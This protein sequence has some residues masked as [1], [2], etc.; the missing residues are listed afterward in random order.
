MR[1][2]LIAFALALTLFGCTSSYTTVVEPP[3]P[4]PNP[5]PNP[6]L[7]QQDIGSGDARIPV[8]HAT[9]TEFYRYQK[10][11]ATAPLA[12]QRA[13]RGIIC[14][15][16]DD[17]S[18]DRVML[19][20]IKELFGE[21]M[22]TECGGPAT[23]H[24]GNTTVTHCFLASNVVAHCHGNRVVCIIANQYYSGVM[25]HEA[26]HALS[27]AQKSDKYKDWRLAWLETLYVGK[28]WSTLSG[29]MS[30]PRDGFV[31]AYATKNHDEDMADVVAA[32]YLFAHRETLHV[33]DPYL[34][35]TLAD[36]RFRLK[37]KTVYGF[38]AITDEEYRANIARLTP[39]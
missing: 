17:D 38:D 35:A 24:W 2:M 23:S 21:A 19:A 12:T 33:P 13:V 10:E 8:L 3:A 14:Y 11:L 6:R 29:K 34:G 18:L 9:E 1:R 39:P 27:F 7:L 15:A 28:S 16:S 31:D 5:T 4:R 25:R 22:A 30:F 20:R 26:F 37:V 36:P 32:S